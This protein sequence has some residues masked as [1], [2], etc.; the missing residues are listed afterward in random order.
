M[1]HDHEIEHDFIKVSILDYSLYSAHS[2]L[3]QSE[4]AGYQRKKSG[5]YK[6]WLSTVMA[7]SCHAIIYMRKYAVDVSTKTILS[8]LK[9]AKFGPRITEPGLFVLIITIPE[10]VKFPTQEDA[11]VGS[12]TFNDVRFSHGETPDGMEGNGLAAPASEIEVEQLLLYQSI[13]DLLKRGEKFGCLPFHENLYREAAHNLVYMFQ[14]KNMPDLQC[15]GVSNPPLRFV[16]DAA[17]NVG[18]DNRRLDASAIRC[19]EAKS[20]SVCRITVVN[21]VNEEV[22]HGTAFLTTGKHLVTCLH[23][24]FDPANGTLRGTRCAIDIIKGDDNVVQTVW[25][26]DLHS[27]L[28]YPHESTLKRGSLGLD[29]AILVLADEVLLPRSHFIPLFTMK[30]SGHISES[31]PKFVDAGTVCVEDRSSAFLIHFP[32]EGQNPRERKRVNSMTENNKCIIGYFNYEVFHECCT[33]V[34]SSGAPAL[35]KD[36]RLLFIHRAGGHK[37]SQKRMTVFFN[38]GVR[39]DM[40]FGADFSFP[41]TV[42]DNRNFFRAFPKDPTID[43][44][45]KKLLDDLTVEYLKE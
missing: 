24:L 3:P 11:F 5:E 28:V 9:S 23:V 7:S 35:D 30:A 18:D 1:E 2:G 45:Y 26:D 31:F 22:E 44:L 16:S 12:A 14:D 41:K 38:L 36:G 27:A 25:I 39:V 32:L 4:E 8:T 17:L 21:E 13:P 19:L 42:L 15:R 40:I 29:L 10:T 37:S 43:T 34:G 20:Y 33:D 6:S